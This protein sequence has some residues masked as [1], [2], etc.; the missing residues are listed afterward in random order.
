MQILIIFFLPL[1]HE[2]EKDYNPLEDSFFQVF[3]IKEK[4]EYKKKKYI[5]P[6]FEIEYGDYTTDYEKRL[7]KY[8]EELSKYE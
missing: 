4:A 5:T 8:H 6:E 7:A 2:Y 1:P 3:K